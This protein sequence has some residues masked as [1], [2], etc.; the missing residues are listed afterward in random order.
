MKGFKKDGKFRPTGN[1]SKSSLKK[2]QIKDIQS[3]KPLTPLG[4]KYQKEMIADIEKDSRS[5]VSLQSE[6][7]LHR[8]VWGN[9]KLIT[10]LTEGQKQENIDALLEGTDPI[11]IAMVEQ[12]PHSS[13]GSDIHRWASEGSFGNH[14]HFGDKLREGDIEGAM[15]RADGDN[16]EYLGKLH[17]ENLLSNVKPHELDPSP[18]AEFLSRLGWAS[19]RTQDDRDFPLGRPTGK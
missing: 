8:P 18:R 7:G 4:K 6:Q 1:K 9:G 16:L 19:G 12:F 13:V 14:G 2:S 3:L 15:F 5:K 17:I 11:Y 10:P